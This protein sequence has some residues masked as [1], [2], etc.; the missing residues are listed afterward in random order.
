LELAR[1]IPRRVIIELT[2]K[3]TAENNPSKDPSIARLWHIHRKNK[4]GRS[5]LQ[6]LMAVLMD[7]GTP[8][9]PH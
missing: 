1:N 6:I 2:P 5:Y 7:N 8:S 4:I 9:K 3:V